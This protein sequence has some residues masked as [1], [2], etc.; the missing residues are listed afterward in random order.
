M[1]RLKAA[2][3]RT[4][5][6][7]G[8]ASDLLRVAFCRTLIKLSNAAFNHQSMSFKDDSQHRLDF[9]S[10]GGSTFL[11]DLRFILKGAAE[12][13]PAVA[14][15]VHGDARDL[16]SYLD[17]RFDLVITSPPYANRMSYIRELR[18]YMYWLGYLTNG[19][20]AGELDWL[21]IGGT[22]GVATSRL[23]DWSA[24]GDCWNPG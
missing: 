2:I 13:P 9:D 24:N 12:N 4:A 8:P 1:C 20:D 22:W 19:R 7:T 3:P 15:V 18:P 16:P 23:G 6:S 21:A 10:E 17:A 14:L 11:D 5:G